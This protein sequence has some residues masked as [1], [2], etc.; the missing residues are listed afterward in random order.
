MTVPVRHTEMSLGVAGCFKEGCPEFF[1][2]GLPDSNRCKHPRFVTTTG[3]LWVQ[4][5]RLQ[6][7]H[8]DN[9]A[10]TMGQLHGMNDSS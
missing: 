8:I 5:V 1:G 6:L 9:G 2:V 3:M 4:A 10:L 7:P